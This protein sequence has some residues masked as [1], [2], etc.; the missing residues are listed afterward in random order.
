MAG[1]VC[2]H[3]PVH[4]EAFTVQPSHP[5]ASTTVQ[6]ATVHRLWGRQT[7][8]SM[9]TECDSIH[10]VPGMIAATVIIVRGGKLKPAE[11]KWLA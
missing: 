9:G 7:C 5:P 11:G 1:A 8:V 10:I 6:G 3:R 2:D 4:L